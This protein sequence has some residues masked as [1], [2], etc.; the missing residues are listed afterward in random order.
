M[1]LGQD[2][3]RLK[4]RPWSLPGTVEDTDEFLSHVSFVRGLSNITLVW[5]NWLR[6]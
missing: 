2:P 5:V 6:F 1:R 3:L 4:W